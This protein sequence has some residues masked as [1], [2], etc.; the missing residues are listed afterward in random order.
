MLLKFNRT[1][2]FPEAYQKNECFAES[3]LSNWLYFHEDY[4][5]LPDEI[6]Y[7][8]KSIA[9]KDVQLFLF[10]FK[11][12]SPHHMA[13]KGYLTAYVAYKNMTDISADPYMIFSDFNDNE[14]T[15]SELNS[16]LCDDS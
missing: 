3:H 13:S 15:M 4:E 16:F 9:V 7:V 8:G 10:K 12:V 2:L 5:A 1:D 6:H 14:L 11:T